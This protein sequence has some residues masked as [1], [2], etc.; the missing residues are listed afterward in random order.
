MSGYKNAADREKDWE[1]RAIKG[2]GIYAVALAIER[3]ADVLSMALGRVAD[4]LNE[5][6][7]SPLQGSSISLSSY[8]IASPIAEALEGLWPEKKP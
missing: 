2:E 1:A 7:T 4:A 3:H 8:D 5:C 6:A